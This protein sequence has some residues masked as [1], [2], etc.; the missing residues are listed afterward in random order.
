[1]NVNVEE[2]AAVVEKLVARVAV[3]ADRLIT[4]RS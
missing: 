2:D 3:A 1:V 4:K